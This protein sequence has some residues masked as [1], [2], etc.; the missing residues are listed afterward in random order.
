MTRVLVTGGAGFIGSR[1]VVAA[2]ARGW[3]V[4]VIDA[5]VPS[6]HQTR[7]EIAREVEFIE[8]DVTDPAALDRCMQGVDVVSHQAAKVGMGVDFS[9]APDY[10][11]ANAVGTAEVLAAM[12]RA[13]IGRL[14]LASSMVVYG[15]G[16]YVGHH[17]DVRPGPRRAEDLQNGMFEPRDPASGEI[18]NPALTVED[19]ILDPRSVY[20]ASKLAQEH[21]ATI[22]A[23]EVGG[24]VAMLRYH[25]V[26]GPGMPRD[27][28]YA[29]VAAI[30]RSSLEHAQAPRVFEDGGQRRD[31]VHVDDIASANVAA[32]E[33]TARMDAAPSRAFNIGSGTVST[34]LDV[35]SELSRVCNG[36]EPIVTGQFRAADVRHITASSERAHAE[37]AWSASVGLAE[38]L[39]EFAASPLRD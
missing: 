35:A 38:G 22:W 1:I 32:M 19:A 15:E 23:H 11:R 3:E 13:E 4:R 16:R 26:Y 24:K 31:F 5:L 37:L 8:A 20:A 10:M 17:G 12:S 30:F 9:D 7:P 6:V 28:P 33:W 14:V 29:G 36:P 25:N 21:L 34:I 39:R 2:L 18:L 27:T